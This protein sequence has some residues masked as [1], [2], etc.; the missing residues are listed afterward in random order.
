MNNW[1]GIKE[2]FSTLWETVK[3]AF[4]VAFEGIQFLALS[5]LV[6]IRDAWSSITGFFGELWSGIHGFFLDTPL[7]PVFEWMVDRVKAVVSPL[8]GFFTNFWGNVS[9]MAGKA[10]GWITD[11]LG[12]VNEFLGRWSDDLREENT[13]L[14]EELNVSGHVKEDVLVDVKSGVQAE[15]PIIESPA[16]QITTPESPISQPTIEKTEIFAQ[17]RH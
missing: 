11:L 3:L 9:D 5:A 14:R 15:K 12:S 7:A 4:Q 1:E 10:L 6:G 16:V 13:K 2:F 17:T 8:L